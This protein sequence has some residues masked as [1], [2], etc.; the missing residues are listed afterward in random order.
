MA[1]T[2]SGKARFDIINKQQTSQPAHQLGLVHIKAAIGQ[3]HQP[4]HLQNNRA[5]GGVCIISNMPCQAVYFDT[6][7]MRGHRIIEHGGG[8]IF[9]N[10]KL[11]HKHMMDTAIL[12]VINFT[13]SH[14]RLNQK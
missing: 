7:L 6:I 5:V 8:V 3:H 13:I 12:K 10:I 1:R 9:L 4:D 11:G 14:R 2:A